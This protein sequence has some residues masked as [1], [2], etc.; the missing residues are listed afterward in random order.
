MQAP[1]YF[2]LFEK[3]DPAMKYKFSEEDG[4]RFKKMVLNNGELKF[5]SSH[6]ENFYEWLMEIHSTM[7]LYIGDR[8]SEEKYYRFVQRVAEA[9]KDNHDFTKCFLGP[10]Y[11]IDSTRR[12]KMLERVHDLIGPHTKLFTKERRCLG[13]V[14]DCEEKKNA[15][16]EIG[17]H[18]GVLPSRSEKELW[19]TQEPDEA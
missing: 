2:A 12:E 5:K 6:K 3:L 17:W 4:K 9:P 8:A 11:E 19:V 16:E 15:K 13:F 1:Y 18:H 14:S 7:S 10:I